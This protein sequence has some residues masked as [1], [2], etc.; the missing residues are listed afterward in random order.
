MAKESS[1]VDVYR[2]RSD[3]TLLL[4]KYGVERKTG[5]VVTVGKFVEIPSDVAAQR[6]GKKS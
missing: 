1:T 4:L 3:G 2:R 5:F 6:G